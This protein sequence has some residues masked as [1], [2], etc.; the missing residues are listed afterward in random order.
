MAFP[1]LGLLPS[2]LKTAARI[3]GLSVL[4]DAGEA[5][6]TAQLTPEQQAQLQEATQRHEAAMK[7]LSIDE[8]RTV[9]SESLTMLQSE[10]RYVKRA[11]PTGLYAF[12][13][14]C[15]AACVAIVLG[16]EVDATALLTV[17]APL[18]G[19]TGTYVWARTKER[20]NGGSGA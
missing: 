12:Y 10:D 19:V 16:V 15:T 2:I 6:A 1:L 20:L 13:A 9:M 17:L 18:G 14:V 3:T 4:K 11:R 5:L 8:L 7:Q